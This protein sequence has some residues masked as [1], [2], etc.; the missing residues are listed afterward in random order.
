MEFEDNLTPKQTLYVSELASG[1][2]TIETALDNFVSHH[3]VRNTIAKAKERVGARTTAN[4]VAIAL[5]KGWIYT[6]A[7]EPPYDFEAL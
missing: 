3:T 2:T 7:E 6:V 5:E 1:K 4:L